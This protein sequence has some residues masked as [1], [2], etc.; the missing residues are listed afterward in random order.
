[1]RAHSIRVVRLA[2]LAACAA[3]LAAA[4]LPAG[5]YAQRRALCRA[6]GG[7]ARRAAGTHRSTDGS[8]NILTGTR[9]GERTWT[10]SWRSGA[11]SLDVRAR[12]DVKFTR[13]A[14][15]I[16]SISPGGFFEIQADDG[17]TRRRLEVRADRGG[18]LERSYFVNGRARPADAEAQE[19]LAGALVELDRRTAFA[20]ESRVPALLRQGGVPA[21]LDEIALVTSDHARRVYFSAL[22]GAARLSAAE[23]RQVLAQAGREIGS[24]FELAELLITAVRRGPLDD[25]A[26]LAYV[27]AAGSIDS[28]F[29]LRRALTALMEGGATS[30]T[31]NKAALHVAAEH[32]GSDFEMRELLAAM[33]RRDLI[34]DETSEA[35]FAAVATIDSDFEQRQALSALLARKALGRP[36]LAA[37]LRSAADGIGSDFELA[38]LLV[39]VAR[40]YPVDDALR[41]AFMRAADTIESDHEH[42]RVMAA[43]VKH[44]AR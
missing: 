44:D 21:V 7:D 10:V 18:A 6:E 36:I 26:R 8:H 4:A 40:Q 12:G 14:T 20:A 31:I 3:V 43:L 42:R 37:L 28:D 30:P 29:E 17:D 15:D 24:D 16:E 27:Q 41:P 22:L 34:A 11:C 33:T 32:L 35:Y 13:D 25:D 1:M 5:G 39:D 9:D 2:A 23:M 38:Q 19:W